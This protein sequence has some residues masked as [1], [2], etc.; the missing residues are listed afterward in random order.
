VTQVA[1]PQ[2]QRRPF[3]TQPWEGGVTGWVAVFGAILIEFI[4]GIVTNTVSMP[5]AA[6]VLLV[7]AAIAVAL[8]LWQWQQARSIRAEP[9]PWWHLIGI[10]VALLA[11]IIWPIV[12][13]ALQGVN[14]AH[15][16]C[17]LVYTAAPSCLARA[18]SALTGSNVTWWVTGAVI[19]ALLPLVRKSRIAVWAA[20][21]VAFAG[22]Q[23]SSHFLELL[24]VHYHATGL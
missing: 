4:A 13:T 22:C 10:G 21:P 15:D 19:V 3:L 24:L 9:V 8:G 11:W 7:P 16:A 2:P 1:R 12:P 18:N 6:P 20:I 23:L 5:V 14:N 17:T